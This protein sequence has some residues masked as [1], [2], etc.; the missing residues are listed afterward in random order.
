MA[1]VALDLRDD[2]AVP[3]ES[4]QE[5]SVSRAA[6]IQRAL[7]SLSTE[8]EMLKSFFRAEAAN[9]RSPDVKSVYFGG[10][11]DDVVRVTVADAFGSVPS[12]NRGVLISAIGEEAVNALFQEQIATKLKPKADTAELLQECLDAGIDVHR[13]FTVS[14][15]LHPV[16]EFAPAARAIGRTLRPDRAERLVDVVE[17]L[18]HKAKVYVNPKLKGSK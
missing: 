3:T 13:Y 17:Q 15:R 8:L 4:G 5:E 10:V 2:A 18:R 9:L 11:G 6:A 12:K 1:K 16:P 7:E 14:A